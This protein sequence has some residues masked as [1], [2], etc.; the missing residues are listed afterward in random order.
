ML[1][2]YITAGLIKEKAMTPT[3]RRLFAP[4]VIKRIELIRLVND[5]GYALREIRE[6]F[7]RRG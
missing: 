3:G 5:S 6:I 7:F 1:Y 2:R 4:D